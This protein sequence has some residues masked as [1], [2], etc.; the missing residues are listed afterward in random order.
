M[1]GNMRQVNLRDFWATTLSFLLGCWVA[2]LFFEVIT[3]SQAIIA[4]NNVLMCNLYITFMI[5]K[6]VE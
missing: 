1:G 3:Q 5:F 2:C 6:K 4:T